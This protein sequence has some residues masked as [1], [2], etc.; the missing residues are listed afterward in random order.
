MRVSA[1]VARRM[2]SAPGMTFKRVEVL[3]AAGLLL[4]LCG[5]C[6]GNGIT[7]FFDGLG[8]AMSGDY[9]GSSSYT[10][11]IEAHAGPS[12]AVGDAGVE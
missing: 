12:D 6:L 4:G 10:Y 5:G 3:L 2:K 11:V 1:V 9:R 8:S 7:S